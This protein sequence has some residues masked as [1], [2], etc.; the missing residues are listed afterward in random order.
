MTIS[1]DELL[2]ALQNPDTVG[3]LENTKETW[4]RIA[5][6]DNFEELGLSKS[7]LDAFLEEWTK[8]NPYENI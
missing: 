1:I 3:T 6:K 5:N 8:D 4:S 2:R 7:E